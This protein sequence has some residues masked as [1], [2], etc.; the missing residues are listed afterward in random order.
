MNLKCNKYTIVRQQLVSFKDPSVKSTS[1]YFIV[2][3]L[4][5]IIILCI[6]IR[7]KI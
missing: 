7:Y 5:K 1:F 4:L 3:I 6:K 2:R